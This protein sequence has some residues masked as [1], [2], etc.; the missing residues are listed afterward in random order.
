MRGRP[1][2]LPPTVAATCRKNVVEIGNLRSQLLR[3]P[4]GATP[5]RICVLRQRFVQGVSEKI[6]L[7]VFCRWLRQTSGPAGHGRSSGKQIPREHQGCKSMVSIWDAALILQDFHEPSLDIFRR[8]LRSNQRV[9]RLHLLDGPDHR[10][11]K[12]RL[13]RRIGFWPREAAGGC[14][15]SRF[16]LK[17]PNMK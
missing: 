17:N 15:R 9:V 7:P 2:W 8:H 6:V 12:C 4:G 11:P 1:N 14:V 16:F 5:N 3:G 13:A 10:F